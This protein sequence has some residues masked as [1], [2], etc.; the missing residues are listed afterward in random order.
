MGMSWFYEEGAVQ[1]KKEQTGKNKA[2][3]DR[4][5]SYEKK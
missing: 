2:D 3:K 4:R 1:W 5:L